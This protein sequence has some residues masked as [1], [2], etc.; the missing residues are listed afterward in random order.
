M[1]EDAD[2]IACG[3]C[4]ERVSGSKKRQHCLPSGRYQG[5]KMQDIYDKALYFGGF[6]E[7]GIVPALWNKVIRRKIL[8]KN[9]LNVHKDI[10]MGEDVAIIFPV[11]AASSCVVIKNEFYPYH[12]RIVSD[13]MSRSYDK[14][15]FLRIEKLLQGLKNNPDIRSRKVMWKSVDYYA[16]FLIEIGLT[17]IFN[18]RENIGCRKIKNVLKEVVEDFDVGNII[19]RIDLEK[20]PAVQKRN[21][22]YL[23]QGRYDFYI[24]RR[25]LGKFVHKVK[26]RITGGMS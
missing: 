24:L 26:N 19:K 22:E 4:E 11:L 9:Q 17:Q 21:W 12:Y 13:S 16:L 7:F 20:F 25:Y 1:S 3:Y 6:Y 18:K 2:V 5:N 23:A 8:L 14:Q 10:R 15:Y